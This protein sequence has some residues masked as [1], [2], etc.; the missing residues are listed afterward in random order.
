MKL[1]DIKVLIKEAMIEQ[2]DS[3]LLRK[4]G[5]LEES[6]FSRA[7]S[8]IETTNVPFV[9]ITAFRG[10]LPRNENDSRLKEMKMTFDSNGLPYVLMPGSG[11]KETRVVDGQKEG[12]V[13]IEDSILVW[14]EP[15]GDKFR[16]E[17]SLFQVAVEL[18]REF[19]QDTFLYGG[20]NPTKPDSGKY[21]IHLYDKE[22]SVVDE[23]WAGG[24]EGY[25]ELIA[26]D[27]AAVYW[28]MIGNKKTKFKE[29]YDKWEKFK[30]KSRLEAMKKDYYIKLA[31]GKMNHD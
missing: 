17:K 13:V 25:A 10:G 26:V 6:N 19:E 11:Y 1:R 20:P 2:K 4:P 27:D 3:I 14:D 12:E 9:M 29:I 31:E 15:R 5:L 24:E 18:T 21:G 22:G 16:T 30:P 28:S 7:K 8:K 23:L